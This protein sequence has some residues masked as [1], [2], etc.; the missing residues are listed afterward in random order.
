MTDSTTRSR[1]GGFDHVLLEDRRRPGRWAARRLVRRRVRPERPGPA[2]RRRRRPARRWSS[3][4]WP[5]STGSRSPTSPPSARGSS[6]R[7]SCRSACRSIKDKPIGNLHKEI[8]ELTVTKAKLAGRA[9][10]RPIEK[11]KAQKERRRPVVAR[12]KR[13]NERKPGM[14]SPRRSPRPRPSSRSPTAMIN[15]AEEQS[16]STRPSWTW[17]SRPSRSTRSSPRSTGSS[18]SG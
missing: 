9:T 11:A 8:A 7:W 1:P 10:S 6:R 4:S 2:P 15:E 5:R 3:T 13:L 18:S 14:V 16:S 12:N 17:P